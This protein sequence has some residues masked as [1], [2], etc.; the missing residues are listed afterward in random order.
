MIRS[1][2]HV[3]ITLLRVLVNKNN[4][5][6]WSTDLIWRCIFIHKRSHSLDIKYN[7]ATFT[8]RARP[9]QT[10]KLITSHHDQRIEIC[11]HSTN[12][13]FQGKHYKQIV[14]TAVRP[15][16]PSILQ[17]YFCKTSKNAALETLVDRVRI[18]R[19]HAGKFLIIK[20]SSLSDFFPQHEHDRELHPVH[21]GTGKI[22]MHAFLGQL[23][24]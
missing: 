16:A 20:K 4:P 5:K 13:T 10:H 8:T 6:W 19:E 14:G 15:L 17:I 2:Y 11:L 9:E 12:F 3:K 18:W 24:L 1:N 21:D 7:Q 22:R 23:K